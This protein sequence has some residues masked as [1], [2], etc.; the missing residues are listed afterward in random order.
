MKMGQHRR[1]RCL[2]LLPLA[3]VAE[4]GPEA[5]VPSQLR[6]RCPLEMMKPIMTRA[7]EEKISLRLTFG[8]ERHQLVLPATGPLDLS[9]ARL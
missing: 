8:P 1:Q 4:A 7:L 2:F 5:V 9:P 3:A 6:R